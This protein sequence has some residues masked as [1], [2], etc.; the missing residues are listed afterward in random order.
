MTIIKPIFSKHDIYQISDVFMRNKHP[1]FLKHR[2]FLTNYVKRKQISMT[3]HTQ[4]TGYILVNKDLTILGNSVALHQWLPEIQ[5]D[6]SGEI[7]TNIFPLLIG[8][9]E[10]LEELIAR[11]QTEPVAISQI[12]YSTT[13]EGDCYFSLQVERCNY[14]EAVLLVTITE[15]TES[16]R[17]E[18][19]LRQERNELRLQII[20]REKVEVALRQELAAHKKTAVALQ[21]AKEAA[22]VA[23]RA[24]SAFLA[25]MSHELRT[26]L[27]GI[28]GYAQIL[29]RDQTLTKIQR[30]W[31][32]IMQ[33][34]GEYL[35]TLIN[36]ILDISKIEANRVEL[37]PTDFSFEGFI[38]QINELFQMKAEQKDITYHYQALTPLPT[39]IHADETRLRQVLINLLGN[40]IKFTE[41]GRVTFKVGSIKDIPSGEKPEPGVAAIRFQVEDSG[42]GIAASELNKIFLPFQQVGH[43]HYQAQGTGLGLAIS[44]KLVEMMG[45]ELYV[46]SVL[47]QGTKFCMDIELSEVSSAKPKP[48]EKR[49]IIGIEGP[50]RK[51]LVV[52]DQWQNRLLLVNLLKPLGFEVMEASNGKESVVKTSQ[53]Q[54][55]IILMDLIMP[56]MDGFEATRSIRQHRELTDVVIIATSASAFKQDQE[57]SFAAG[58]NDFIAKPI[59]VDEMLEKLREH[60]KLNWV[61]QAYHPK[62]HS[63][64]VSAEST[65]ALVVPPTEFI[66][67][68]HKLTMQGHVDGIIELATQLEKN[69]DKFKPFTTE[70]LRLA[71]DFQ[72]R[73]IRE[74]IKPYL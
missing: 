19:A 49:M 21:Q 14:A 48:T 47:E 67:T 32:D 57:R 30:E 58:C 25:N 65:Q 3:D 55:D 56:V 31:V 53:F 6:L 18:Q 12:S 45:G 71:N 63:Q 37:L 62:A 23:N 61:Y 8:Y 52:D 27:N 24:K 44:K 74:W 68:L 17:L 64:E 2:M 72:I 22:E 38:K 60:L 51:A 11:Q 69:D 26:P 5:V 33:R 42:I 20:E 73:K 39:I 13:V 4:E 35:L 70:L 36:D 15:V 1:M 59:Q 9:E 46:E 66:K 29:K 7:L 54:P 34:S 50:S 40:A 16:A 43:S 10:Q 41:H 28:L